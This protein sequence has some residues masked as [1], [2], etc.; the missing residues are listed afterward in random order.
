MADVLA[1]RLEK[2]E[3]NV[4]KREDKL[5]NYK[6]QMTFAEENTFQRNQPENIIVSD[7]EDGTKKV[8][9][10]VVPEESD[11]SFKRASNQ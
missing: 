10:F 4:K 6:Q 1:A 9:Q 2:I 7:Q 3:A 5:S 8:R 11:E